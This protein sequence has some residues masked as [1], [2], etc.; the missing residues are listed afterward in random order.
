MPGSLHLRVRLIASVRVGCCENLGKM[1]GTDFPCFKC[2]W[3]VVAAFL[4]APTSIGSFVYVLDRH[5]LE[6]VAWR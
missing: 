3:K 6:A 5:K 1:L 2:V 4:R